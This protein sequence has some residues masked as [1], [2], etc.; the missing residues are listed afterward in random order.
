ML[1]L[2][3]KAFGQILFFF[4]FVFLL[5]WKILKFLELITL[6]DIIDRGV[7]DHLGWVYFL[8]RLCFASDAIQIIHFSHCV[9]LF[10]ASAEFIQTYI[11]G[12]F[13]GFIR[14]HITCMFDLYYQFENLI[15]FFQ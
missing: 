10:V 6:S 1:N 12:L 11:V 7:C 15:M 3:F 8:Y 9:S 5:I 13:L 2:G 4:F 14:M